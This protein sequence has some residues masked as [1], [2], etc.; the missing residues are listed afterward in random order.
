MTAR[1]QPGEFAAMLRTSVF[2][3]RVSSGVIERVFKLPDG[4]DEEKPAAKY[5]VH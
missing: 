4:V 3:T 1:Q 2:V 5:A